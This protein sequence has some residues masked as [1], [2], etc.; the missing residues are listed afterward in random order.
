MSCHDVVPVRVPQDSE[1]TI[2]LLI[3][4][5][6]VCSVRNLSYSSTN[7]QIHALFRR[8]SIYKFGI[9]HRIITPVPDT[10]DNNSLTRYCRQNNC[11][12][13]SAGTKTSISITMVVKTL[14]RSCIWNDS[15]SYL[16]LRRTATSPYSPICINYSCA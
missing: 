12:H 2:L 8:K 9:K 15:H 16:D 3:L 1:S 7:N 11:S 13:V 14:F 5:I 10:S 4:L 6:L